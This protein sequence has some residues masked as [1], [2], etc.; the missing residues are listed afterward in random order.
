MNAR[1]LADANFRHAIFSGVRRREPAIDFV[2]VQEAGLKDHPDP[3]ILAFAA[4]E[5]RILVSHDYRTMPV[6][7][8]EF[9]SKQSSPGVFLIPQKSAVAA[10]IDALV[11]IWAASEAEEWRNRL[12]YVRL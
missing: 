2:T 10:A 4:R 1:F 11:L 9:V 5:N 7:F 8:Q 3:D 12:T 6:H